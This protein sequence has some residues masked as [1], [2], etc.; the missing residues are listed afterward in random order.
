MSLALRSFPLGVEWWWWDCRGVRAEKGVARSIASL[1]HHYWPENMRKA[2]FAFRTSVWP[3]TI[4]TDWMSCRFFDPS[5]FFSDVCSRSHNLWCA[6]L[7]VESIIFRFGASGRQNLGRFM[8]KG[9]TMIGQIYRWD[10]ETGGQRDRETKDRDRE[11]ETER[12][13]RQWDSQSDRQ[14]DR[15][16]ERASLWDSVTAMPER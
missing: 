7:D 12:Q 16:T 3:W 10:R 6:Y 4:R 14:T 8:Y 15:Q 2:S 1:V 9:F 13:E 5:M 11:T